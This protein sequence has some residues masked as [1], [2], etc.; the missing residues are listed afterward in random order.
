MAL[1]V[2]LCVLLSVP[3]AGGR[4]HAASPCEAVGADPDPDTDAW[5]VAGDRY[6]LIVQV[7]PG[8]LTI[9]RHFGLD[10][11]ACAM[12]G[13]GPVRAVRVDAVMPAHRHGMNYR[14][15]VLATGQGRFEVRGLLLHMPGRWRWTFELDGDG[16]GAGE[17]LQ[18]D[19]DVE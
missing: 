9:G 6:R 11:Q 10:I 12:G 18:F 8:P 16:E 17:R 7:Q 15:T 14:P 4:A 5:V 2:A 19:Q 1:C 13:A 3:L